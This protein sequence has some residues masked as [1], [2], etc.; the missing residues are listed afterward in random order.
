MDC[1]KE[2]IKYTSLNVMGMIGLSCYILADTYFIAKGMGSRG[3]TALNLAIPIY[4]FIN[5][6]ALM[7]GMGGATR[8]SIAKS[9]GRERRKNQIFTHTITMVLVCAS[10][11]VMLGCFF[12]EK[13]TYLLGAD[14][15]IFSMCRTYLQVLLLFSPAFLFNQTIL[16]FVRNDGVPHLSMAAML[17][18]S[19]SNIVLDYV[20]IFLFDMGIFGA[21]IA[22]GF[23]PVISLCMLS[24]HFWKKHHQFHIIKCGISRR[25]MEQILAS[26]I[27]SLISELSSGTVM[28]IF[29][30]ILLGMAGNT[31]VA[32]YGIIANIYL[33][34]ISIYTGIAQ[35]IQPLM[36][37]Y[38]GKK[39]TKN[40]Q[41][42]FWYGIFTVIILS[43]LIYAVMFFRADEISWLF[44]SEGNDML[45]AMA[46]HGI[47]L[48]FIVFLFAGV[49]RLM[50]IYFA[51]TNRARPAN[52]ISMLRGFVLIVPM[53][54][55]MSAI[56]GINGLWLAS[57]VTE[58]LV[59]IIGTAFYLFYRK[60]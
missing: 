36:S 52:I 21:A 16:S 59:A 28:M 5:G 14:K 18:G 11:F 47:K 6:T 58:I 26:G 1:L 38:Y 8:Y 29:N 19:F 46:V 15:E 33:V 22:T 23:A 27:P 7:L 51:S 49:N 44:N 39:K 31:G 45:Q 20:F 4:N 41:S 37:N 53:S 3:L 42:V 40:I 25:S 24:I 43:I 2:Y 48:Y 55:L 9:Q 57:P 56:G 35:G 34:I 10:F 30:M 54:F 32:A 60:A 12:S 50:A 13:I 17:A